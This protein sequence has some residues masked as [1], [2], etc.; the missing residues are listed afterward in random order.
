V[1]AS[2]APEPIRVL[3]ASSDRRVRNL[4][5]RTLGSDP[6]FA[7]IAEA[8]TGDEAIAFAEA[9]QL[10]VV[11]LTIPGLGVFG[12]L[13]NLRH[14]QPRRL[15]VITAPTGV[16]YLRHAAAVEGADDYVVLP[17]EIDQLTDRLLRAARPQVAVS[18]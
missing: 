12:V 7:V 16:V 5:R 9:Y 17:D 4:L 11:D 8:A 15:V 10:A 13:S 3:I 14:L 6:R 1:I 2:P 18:A